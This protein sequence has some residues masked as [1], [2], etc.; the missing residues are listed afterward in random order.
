MADSDAADALRRWVQ[1]YVVVSLAL[2]A[3]AVTLLCVATPQWWVCLLLVG[4]AVLVALMGGRA[5]QSLQGHRDLAS[6]ARHEA[7][8]SRRVLVHVFDSVLDPMIV[9]DEAG[10]VIAAN[11]A[12]RDVFGWSRDDL[13]GKNVNVLM[14]DPYRGEH[15]GY[16]RSYLRTGEQRAIGRVRRVLGRRRDG[17][18]F[19]C[20]LSVSQVVTEEGRRFFGVVRDVSEQEDFALRMATAERLA[21]VGEVA[22]G[23]AHEVNN[24]IN[25]IINCAQMIKEGDTAPELCD[26]VIH[27]GL[28][29]A[30]FV[31]ELMGV[32]ADRDEE[33]VLADVHEPLR[34]A[35]SLLGVRMRHADVEVSVA[36]AA[37]L[38]PVSARPRRLQQVFL[39]LLINALDALR[40]ADRPRRRVDV[41]TRREVAEGKDWVVVAV[42]DNGGGVPE[43][44]RERIFQPFFT[45]KK[46]G[47]GTGL[48]L[49]V[50]AGIVR[51]HG[52]RIALQSEPDVFAEFSVW[53]PAAAR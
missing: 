24:P 22:A 35:I 2:L 13:V 36:E 25:T 48:G 15:D 10:K 1:A 51:D 49:A 11:P 41:W 21:A 31:R 42:R 5:Q 28:R 37:A 9:I 40:A 19:P 26:H 34:R 52:G 17:H 46:P 8:A 14:G 30:G 3:V 12:V 16:I 18:E 27:E 23:I 43:Y 50:S 44:A 38:P 6:A 47:E 7:E 45:T 32:A 33:F 29:I 39:N 20:E 53:L 4:V